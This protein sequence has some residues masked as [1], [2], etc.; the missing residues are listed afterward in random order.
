M[1]NLLM[2]DSRRLVLPLDTTVDALIE[3][4]RAHRRWPERVTLHGARLGPSGVVISVR[5]SGQEAPIERTYSLAIVAAAIIHYCAKMRVPVPKNASKSVSVAQDGITMVLEGTLFLQRQHDALPEE[6]AARRQP[7]E[8]SRR[9]DARASEQS[10][11][12]ASGALADPSPAAGAA[13]GAVDAA[14]ASEEGGHST[15]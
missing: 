3:F 6:M 12:A 14:V 15:T 11:A 9:A 5:Q 10:E 1:T 13:T 2:H 4:D 8:E 7:T